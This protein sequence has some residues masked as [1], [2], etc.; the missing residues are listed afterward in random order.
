MGVLEGCYGIFK[1]KSEV[2]YVYK[3][4]HN[5]PIAPFARTQGGGGGGGK[6]I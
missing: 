2:V 5:T 6:V 1:E 3:E 4:P